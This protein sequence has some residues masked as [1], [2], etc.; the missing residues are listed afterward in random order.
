[1]RNSQHVRIAK[2]YNLGEQGYKFEDVH[3]KPPFNLIV[4][5][6]TLKNNE[7]LTV[8]YYFNTSKLYRIF[9]QTRTVCTHSEI[10]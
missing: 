10:S 2:I 7:N 4:L 3:I 9:Q 8:P 6:S 1:M 5:M